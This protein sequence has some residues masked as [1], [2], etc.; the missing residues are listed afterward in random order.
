[1]LRPG[2]RYA[3]HELA[4][5]PDDIDPG[6]ATAIRKELARSIKVNA[7]PL[8]VAE[9][10]ELLAESGLEIA[11]VHTAPMA[12]LQL[13]RN[14]QDEGVVGVARMGLNLVRDP[15][16]R[17][18]VMEMRKTFTKYQD[19]LIAVAIVAVLPEKKEMQ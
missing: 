6:T 12:L 7:R 5:R 4:L 3:I 13:G 9:W 1:M 10:S 18:R 19:A 8:T 2:G 14:V 11:S 16:V 15:A 17:R